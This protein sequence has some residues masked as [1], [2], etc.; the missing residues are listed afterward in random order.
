MPT[1]LRQVASIYWYAMSLVIL[2]LI[3]FSVQSAQLSQQGLVQEAGFLNS[4][5]TAFG[6]AILFGGLIIIAQALGLLRAVNIL[7]TGQHTEIAA[8]VGAIIGLV[9]W[10]I[11]TFSGQSILPFLTLPPQFSPF[12]VATQPLN[13]WVK[14]FTVDMAAPIAEEFLFLIG[15]PTVIYSMLLVGSRVL[16]FGLF[17]HPIVLALITIAIDAPLFAYFHVANQGIFPLLLVSMAFRT[18]MLAVVFNRFTHFIPL[19]DVVATF[20]IFAHIANNINSTGGITAFIT[21]ML[22][23]APGIVELIIGFFAVLFLAYP[24]LVVFANLKL[25]PRF[26]LPR[27]ATA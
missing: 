27:I 1:P 23:K 17:G 7:G 12:A 5:S 25:L 14:A 13:D 21:T 3:Y 19:L 26:S 8:A 10:G 16:K 11:L 2:A 6:I 18:V 4:A 22:F 9:A 20:S 15:L 24:F